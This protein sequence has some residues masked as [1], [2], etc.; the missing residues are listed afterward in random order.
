MTAGTIEVDHHGSWTRIFIS[1]AH[2]SGYYLNLTFTCIPN[3]QGMW[4]YNIALT[5]AE[6]DK[7]ARMID[8]LPVDP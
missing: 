4:N 5:R 6:L 2:P 3:G 7:L 1:K 8:A